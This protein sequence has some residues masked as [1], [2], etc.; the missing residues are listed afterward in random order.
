MKAGVNAYWMLATYPECFAGILLLR[1]RIAL[2]SST[3]IHA[4][5]EMLRPM[6]YSNNQQSNLTKPHWQENL[7]SE[8]YLA[9]EFFITIQQ[10][11]TTQN[12]YPRMAGK[13][14]SHQHQT[15]ALAPLYK[16]R[17]F[18]LGFLCGCLFSLH[19]RIWFFLWVKN[20]SKA[21]KG[22]PLH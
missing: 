21:W 2:G 12:V 10:S 3:T 15:T 7:D 11:L 4:L 13:S 16:E 22:H 17:L 6:H 19:V 20:F 18:S 14:I 8:I 5:R 9:I 1:S